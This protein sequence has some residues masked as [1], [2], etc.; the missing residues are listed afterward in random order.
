V[1]KQLGSRETQI[2]SCLHWNNE[3]ILYVA[4]KPR[5]RRP[6]TID[7]GDSS[8]HQGKIVTCPELVTTLR[9]EVALSVLR[10][11]R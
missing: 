4:L 9:M 3:L 10:T 11:T 6:L 5:R 7:D 2:R 8:K 1:I